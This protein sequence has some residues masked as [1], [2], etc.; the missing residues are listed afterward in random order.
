[1]STLNAGDAG[2]TTGLSGLIYSKL[3]ADA[4]AGFSTPL[5]T[6]Q[7]DSLRAIAWSI[8]QGVSQQVAADGGLGG[9]GVGG[10]GTAG[11][12]AAWTGT[13]TIGNATAEAWH[14]VGGAGEPAF[15]NGWVN[16]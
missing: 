15:Q 10:S 7:E 3:L 4:R 16:Y 13:G 11:S 6:S 9:G 14:V 12:L 8:A 2:C 1:M 5:S